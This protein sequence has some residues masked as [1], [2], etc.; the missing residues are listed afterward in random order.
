M[1][2]T[3]AGGRYKVGDMLVDANG[4]ELTGDAAKET[5]ES[6]GT[7]DSTPPEYPY[8]DVLKAGGFND[9]QAVQGASDDDLLDVDGIG[10]ARLKEIRE[11]KG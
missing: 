7:G 2:E 6:A 1:A 9:W 11:F 5:Q 8:A 3:V 4:K 10:P